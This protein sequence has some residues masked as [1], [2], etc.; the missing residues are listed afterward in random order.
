MSHLTLSQRYEISILNEQKLSKSIIAERIGK[1]KSTIYRELRRNSDGRS[2]RYKA[3][4]AQRKCE[5]RHIR[6]N[7]N[8]TLQAA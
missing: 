4:L 2:G 5:S 3:D 8:E 1:N 7:K 6:K